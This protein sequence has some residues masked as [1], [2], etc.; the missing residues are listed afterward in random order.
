M[1][2][3]VFLFL[4]SPPSYVFLLFMYEKIKKFCLK[5]VDYV[6]VLLFL[7]EPKDTKILVPSKR[8]AWH[9]PRPQVITVQ[10]EI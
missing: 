9:L 5:K 6:S 8:Y 4:S 2:L 7:P 3:F 1:D 10:F